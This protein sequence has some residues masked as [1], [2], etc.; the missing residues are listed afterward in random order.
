MIDFIEEYCEY[1]GYS[2]ERLDGRVSGNDRQKGID[3]FNKNEDSFVFLLSTRAGGVGINLTAADTCIIFDSDWNPQNDVQAM[4]R[5]HR[6][7]QKKQVTVYRLITRSSFEAEMFDRASKKLGLEQ[8]IMGSKEFNAEEMDGSGSSK[9][10]MDAKELEQLLREGAYAVFMHAEAVDDEEEFLTQDIDKI[11][12]KRAHV[13]RDEPGAQTESWLNKKKKSSKTRKQV[14]TGVDEGQNDIDLNDPDFWAKVLPDL[15]TPDSLW[16]R[17]NSME[18][19]MG[20]DDRPKA[21]KARVAHA[22]KFFTDLTSL[23]DGMLDLIRREQMPDRE[24]NTCSSILL[25]VTLKETLFSDEERAQAQEWLVLTEG[26]RSRR[27]VGEHGAGTGGKRGGGGKRTGGMRKSASKAGGF[28]E[29][30]EDSDGQPMAPKPSTHVSF[31][32]IGEYLGSDDEDYDSGSFSSLFP[33]LSYLF[34]ALTLS[35]SLSSL[36]FHLY[37]QTTPTNPSAARVASRARAKRTLHAAASAT[38]R[39]R[40]A[41]P[42][43]RRPAGPEKRSFPWARAASSCRRPSEAGPRTAYAP[44][45]THP[46]CRAGEPPQTPLWLLGCRGLPWPSQSRTTPSKMCSRA[47]LLTWSRRRR[48]TEEQGPMRG[49]PTP[50]TLR[51]SKMTQKGRD[52]NMQGL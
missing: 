52:V 17:L 10:K 39:R 13:Y 3:R 40:R 41:H 32:E 2:V 24:R 45:P 6:I 43:R 42:R 11:L 38:T 18:D 51:T 29:E 21:V 23:M 34:L 27:Q 33:I 44:L 36:L 50:A 26:T 8:A 7:G 22:R 25:G 19:E 9:P 46:K 30:D 47:A 5:C 48:R 12:E 14:F 1:R 20:T 35:L 4:A 15:V 16:S 28:D 37:A 31:E 49:S